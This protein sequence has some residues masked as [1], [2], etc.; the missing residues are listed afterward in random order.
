MSCNRVDN[1][2]SIVNVTAIFTEK[3]I[4]RKISICDDALIA[5]RDLNV[6]QNADEF[7]EKYCNLTT[8]YTCTLINKT[9]LF[10]EFSMT[11]LNS[12][13]ALNNKPILYLIYYNCKSGKFY[14]GK[15]YF[16]K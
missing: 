3:K 1:Q 11:E 2:I 4:A 6:T 9:D 10:R 15:Q 8:S 14:I 13:L 5:S 16:F 7:Q 12:N